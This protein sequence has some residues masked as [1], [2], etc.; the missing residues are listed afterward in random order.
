[1]EFERAGIAPLGGGWGESWDVWL[2]EV[3][4]ELA[5]VMVG[6]GKWGSGGGVALADVEEVGAGWRD[7]WLDF[8]VGLV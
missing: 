1:M 5:A 6:W 7:F 3:E 8:R 2:Q 4:G